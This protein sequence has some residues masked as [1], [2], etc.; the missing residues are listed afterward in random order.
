MSGSLNANHLL[1]LGQGALWTIGL[2]LIALVGGGALGFVIALCRISALRAVRFASGAYVQLIQG[3]PLLVIMFLTFFGLPPLGLRVSP[4]TAAGA[5]LTIYVGA[6]LGEIWRGAI[7]SVP[8]PQWEAAEGLALSRAQRMTKVILP[9]AVR[10]ATPPTVGFMVQIVKNTSLASVVGFVEL[11][12]AGQIINNSLFEPF[13]I[14]AIIAAVYF[15]MCFPLSR[16]S[17]RLER[18]GARGRTTLMPA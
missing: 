10:I 16:L 12:R 14:Y 1:F 15:A 2:S 17:Q 5:S 4:L 6:Y 18:R 8:R 7:Q 13:L 11:A 3:T 9:Q